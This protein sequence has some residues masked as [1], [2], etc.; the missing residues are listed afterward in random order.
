M[1]DKLTQFDRL[2][3]FTEML[4]LGKD[5]Y[6]Y[7]IVIAIHLLIITILGTFVSLFFTI[8]YIVDYARAFFSFDKDILMFSKALGYEL[9]KKDVLDIFFIKA[10]KEAGYFFCATAILYTASFLLINKQ[11]RKFVKMLNKNGDNADLAGSIILEDEKFM[12]KYMSLR[13]NSEEG[14][15]ISQVYEF[16]EVDKNGNVKED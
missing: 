2:S 14:I 9:L 3:S 12:D 6:Y 8:D 11:I 5:T 13:K 1:S 15:L 16:K 7:V 10:L 4:K